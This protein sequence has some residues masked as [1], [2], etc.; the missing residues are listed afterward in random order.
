MSDGN[1]SIP[2]ADRVPPQ[3]GSAGASGDDAVV[4]DVLR[5]LAGELSAD[6]VTAL[7]VR[8]RSDASA[9]ELF[10]RVCL[11]ESWLTEKFA[12]GRREFL[13]QMMLEE[14]E[15]PSVATS[16]DAVSM[17]AILAADP[18]TD[19]EPEPLVV[20]SW[21][22]PVEPPPPWWKRRTTWAA[23]AVLLLA[24]GVWATV[25]RLFRPEA[26]A[27]ATLSGAQDV[28][29]NTS[30]AAP[31]IGSA[32]RASSDLRLQS[33]LIR[34]TFNGGAK[35]VVEG[36]ARFVPEA[37]GRLRLVNGRMTALVPP[38]AKGFTVR[39]PTAE[40]VDLGTE[41]GIDVPPTRGSPVEVQVFDGVVTLQPAAVAQ[42][43]TAAAA[44]PP[45]VLKAG[46]GVRV[47]PAGTV[48]QVPVN[49]AMFVRA[50]EADAIERAAQS[51]G[52]DRWAAYRYQLARDPD[53]VAYYPFDAENKARSP[54]RLTNAAGTGP[55]LDGTLAGDDG[56]R[57]QWVAGRWPEKAALAFGEVGAPRVTFPGAD[58]ALDF[59]RGPV[60]GEGQAFTVAAW[61]KA[62]PKP[63]PGVGVVARGVRGAEQFAL[64]TESTFYRFVLRDGLAADR[65][66]VLNSRNYVSAYWHHVVATYEPATGAAR[67][68]VDGAAVND[69]APG[70]GVAPKMLRPAEG[71]VVLG[72]RVMSPGVFGMPLDGT[73]DEL[74][75]IRR[76]ITPGEVR[77]MYEAGKPN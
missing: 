64:E 30:S 53:V 46:T 1:G 14:S 26:P 17:P 12:P 32:L 36:P 16:I 73:V 3:N 22:K 23:A 18:G 33:G 21:P 13:A 45:Q 54:D 11:L 48:T 5:Y 41:F 58:A 37:D 60:P 47:D 63:S 35:V 40:I 7:G 29:W 49:P 2:P 61:F 76:A 57:P 20:P 65:R 66:S 42:Q 44:P 77:Q 62:K 50:A 19:A 28:K 43:Q 27:V 6:E 34:L 25:A 68:Y 39:T 59:S 52:F 31:A 71:P 15:E 8:L 67:L 70:A 38:A 74:V 24:V 75:F 10:V 9:R 56:A 72:C 4:L 69:Q 51:S 55:A